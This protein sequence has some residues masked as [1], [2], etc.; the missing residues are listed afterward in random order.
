M[1]FFKSIVKRTILVI[2]KKL[3]LIE[4]NRLCD[5]HEYIEAYN[6]WKKYSYLFEV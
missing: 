1:K 6:L 4:I 2:C 5:K 3:Y